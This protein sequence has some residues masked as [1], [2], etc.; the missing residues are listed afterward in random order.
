MFRQPAS[1]HRTTAPHTTYYLLCSTCS[2]LPVIHRCLSVIY[3]LIH[4]PI[5][6]FNFW[7]FFSPTCLPLP[8]YCTRYNLL[9]T[10]LYLPPTTCYTSRP[11]CY[12]IHALIL[13]FDFW[14]FFVSPSCLLL[15]HYCTTYY[16]LPTMLHLLPTNCYTSLPLCYLLSATYFNST[17]QLL[18]FFVSGPSIWALSL[19]KTT[20]GTAFGHFR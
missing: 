14:T 11:I 7:T 20:V 8:H 4:T 16:L 15:P 13:Q 19:R 6:Q 12:L 5:L 2:P 9:P 18:D 3:Y 17:I 10:M 1:C